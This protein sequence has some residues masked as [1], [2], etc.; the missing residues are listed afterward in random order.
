MDNLKVLILIVLFLSGC[1]VV[2]AW[3]EPAREKN[4]DRPG[5]DLSSQ[6]PDA[7][8]D[9]GCDVRSLEQ[10]TDRPG[11]DYKNF[12][13]ERPD[14]CACMD[15]CTGDSRCQAFTYVEPG[16][17]GEKARCWLKN[18][19]PGPESNPGC[20]SGVK[21]QETP[22]DTGCDARSLEQ[23]TDRPGKDYQDFDLERPDPCACMNSCTGDSRCQAFTYVEPGIQGEK[24][25]CWLKNAVPGPE[26]N[27]GCISG[28]KKQETPDDTGCDARSL[29]QGTDRPGKDYQDFDLESPDPCACMDSC[30]GD[31]RC[32]AYTYVKPGIQGEKARCWLK[33]DVP[34]PVSSEC[35]TSGV[36]AY[37]SPR[38]TE[39]PASYPDLKPVK[40]GVPPGTQGYQGMPVS[41]E[42]E[43]TG[44]G[45]ADPC[46]GQLEYT[47]KSCIG[48]KTD[49]SQSI[50]GSCEYT[51]FEIPSIPKG[52][53]KTVT[54]SLNVPGVGGAGKVTLVADLN[55]AGTVKESDYSNNA[56]TLIL[57]S[58]AGSCPPEATFED[59]IADAVFIETNAA[60]SQKN[61]APLKRNK[62]IDGIAL[63][64]AKYV[65]S[66]GNANHDNVNTRYAE[67]GKLGFGPMGEN[68]G[69]VSSG[70]Q[71]DYCD[72][73]PHTVANTPE[74]LAKF[75]VDVFVNHDSCQKYGHRDNILSSKYT[76]IGI[77]VAQGGGYYYIVQ[78]FA[79]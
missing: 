51:Y 27:P 15:S 57:D 45:D 18:A 59:K 60:R 11:K 58:G 77:A 47:W 74:G 25:R 4:I 21:K 62:S 13:L 33:S 10:G 52:S 55:Y 71:Y 64:H 28:V 16:I 36:I 49:G 41:V 73:Q 29:E 37:P 42:I 66:K 35:C 65:A 17:Q 79:G 38:R 20:I 46:K 54:T 39:A 50:S 8:D 70:S 53:K 69:P 24:A 9:T 31:P 68:V 34:D 61:L 32:K 48:T 40:I 67:M 76:D 12:D 44:Q 1:L 14:P 6:V 2:S 63:P 26:S 75:A 78:D 43:N 72:K 3:A 22:D 19:V 56:M 7:P 5:R 23:G 30:R